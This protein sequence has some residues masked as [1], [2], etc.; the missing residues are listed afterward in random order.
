MSSNI[1][2]ARTITEGKAD[3]QTMSEVKLNTL[4][5]AL[6]QVGS[7]CGA[8][9]CCHHALSWLLLA[10]QTF[11]FPQLKPLPVHLSQLKLVSVPLSG[12]LSWTPKYVFNHAVF[13]MICC[14]V[15]S[16]DRIY[17]LILEV[18]SSCLYHQSLILLCRM[19]CQIF[20]PDISFLLFSHPFFDFSAILIH[21]FSHC[22]SCAF[23]VSG[24]FWHA[25]LFARKTHGSRR[26]VLLLIW[27]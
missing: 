19:L 14:C 1:S 12:C 7:Q 5:G 20:S 2:T 6:K 15:V 17:C 23:P 16:F 18:Q 8:L 9:K 24:F 10:F 25:C 4:H 26:E 3:S 27:H 11:L 21:L 13:K 22:F